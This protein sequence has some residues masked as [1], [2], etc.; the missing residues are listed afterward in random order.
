MPLVMYADITLQL[1]M[2]SIQNYIGLLL[3]C[4]IFDTFSYMQCILLSQENKCRRNCINLDFYK[5]EL[6]VRLEIYKHCT[7]FHEE[8][9]SQIKLLKNS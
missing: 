2:V 7:Q 6:E 3:Q 5:G 9:L 8:E 4:L 1:Y